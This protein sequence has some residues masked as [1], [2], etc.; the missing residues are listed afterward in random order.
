M[1]H[2]LKYTA[3]RDTLQMY[4]ILHSGQW[5]CYFTDFSEAFTVHVI[6]YVQRSFSYGIRYIV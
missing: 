2:V 6:T 1:H 4:M 3:S 5:T